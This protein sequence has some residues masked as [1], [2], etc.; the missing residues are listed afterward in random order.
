MSRNA[1]DVYLRF[2]MYALV[3]RSATRHTAVI[4]ISLRRHIK[5]TVQLL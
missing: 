3:A 4:S 2:Q 5:V 1:D